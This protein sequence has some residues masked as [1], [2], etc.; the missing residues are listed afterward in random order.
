MAASDVFALGAVF[1][2]VMRG[3]GIRGLCGT[4][5]PGADHGTNR[6][7]RDAHNIGGWRASCNSHR[8][9]GARSVHER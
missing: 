8:A 9:V 3:L 2:F 5:S 6:D 7:V 1:G 4:P